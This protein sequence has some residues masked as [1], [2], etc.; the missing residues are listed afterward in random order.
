M[1]SGQDGCGEKDAKSWRWRT[2]SKPGWD[3]QQ[4][5]S[6][7]SCLGLHCT[8][9]H[10]NVMQFE[11]LLERSECRMILPLKWQCMPAP[12]TLW[13]VFQHACPCRSAVSVLNTWHSCIACLSR[14]WIHPLASL[15]HPWK[16]PLYPNIF[17]SILK[18]YPRPIFNFVRVSVGPLC[19][20]RAF[21]PGECRWGL[22]AW[23]W[24]GTEDSTQGYAGPDGLGHKVNIHLRFSQT[25]D[26]PFHKKIL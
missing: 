16:G 12:C 8:G 24:S 4:L 18:H 1:L 20:T 9:D 6:Y 19:D 2:L 10:R 14:I 13:H 7:L 26:M 25:E 23:I 22:A 17:R 15:V 11:A 5:Q 21:G 3:F